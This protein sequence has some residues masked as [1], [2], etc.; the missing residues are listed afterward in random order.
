MTNFTSFAV[1]GGTGRLGQHI[2]R[3]LVAAGADVVVLSRSTDNMVE[4]A[5][6][7]VVGFESQESLQLALEGVE[8]VVSALGKPALALQPA[9]ARAAKYV[10]R[11]AD[12]PLLRVTPRSSGTDSFPPGKHCRAAGVQL[13]VPSEFGIASRRFERGMPLC[14][15]HA[16]IDLLRELDL[17]Y[18]AIATGAFPELVFTQ[19][20]FGLNYPSGKAHVV[21]SPDCPVSASLYCP[22]AVRG[23]H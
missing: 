7:R 17:P 11:L 12:P 14:G 5:T 10:P 4:G 16:A 3:Q 18:I 9:L 15:Q 21:G 20:L 19:P 6:T 22:I 2:V 23:Q 13:F 8:V 1:A